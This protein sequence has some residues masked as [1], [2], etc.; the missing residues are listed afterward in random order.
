VT[1]ILLFFSF[2]SAPTQLAALAPTA[3][4]APR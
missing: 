2:T 4:A 1:V 3:I